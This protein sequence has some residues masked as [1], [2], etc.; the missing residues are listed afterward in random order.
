[1]AL[2]DPTAD[3]SGGADRRATRSLSFGAIAEDYDRFRPGPP[4]E[5]VEWIL[6]LECHAVVDIGAGTGALTRLLVG[7]GVRVTAVEPDA[8]MAAVLARRV[9]SAIVLSARAEDLPLES[10]SVD[11]VV[12]SS[13]WHWVDVERATH[14]AARVLRPGGLLGILGTGPD[15]SQAWLAEILAAARPTRP[16]AD[17][18]HR[19]HLELQLPTDAPFSVPESHV[20][21][22]SLS[23]SP[24]YLVELACT[25]SEFI[26]LPEAEKKRARDKV[27]EVVAG[28]PALTDQKQITLPMRCLC[29]RARRHS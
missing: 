1:V 9:P 23:V 24:D 14:E 16:A 18:A 29:W 22:W 7:D 3:P 5:A 11:A 28:H 15:L 2:D 19:P 27:T 6:P 21:S 12:G 13:M 8:R 17:V 4:A 26:V 20:F 25:Y 10:G